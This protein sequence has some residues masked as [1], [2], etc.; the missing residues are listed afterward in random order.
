M[1]RVKLNRTTR[2]ALYFLRFY[3][4]FLFLLLIFRFVKGFR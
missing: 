1:P 4:L 3:L 2:T